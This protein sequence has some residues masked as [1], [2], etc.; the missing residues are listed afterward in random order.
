[1]VRRDPDCVDALQLLGDYYTLHGRK[2]RIGLKLK[3][4]VSPFHR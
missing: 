2:L 1:M 3:F 4:K